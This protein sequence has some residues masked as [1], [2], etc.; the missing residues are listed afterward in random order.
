MELLF[1]A[2]AG[3][4]FGILARYVQ[5]G[6]SYSGVVVIPAVGTAVASTV[7]VILTWF[8]WAWDGGWIWV[9]SLVLSGVVAFVSARILSTRREAA[10]KELLHTLIKTGVPA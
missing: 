6:R 4:L 10:D 7:W 3:A 8:G 9:V 5:P 1:V 2:L